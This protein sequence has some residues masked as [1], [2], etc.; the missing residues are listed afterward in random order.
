M[1]ANSADNPYSVVLKSAHY[2]LSTPVPRKWVGNTVYT[3][4]GSDAVLELP[5][6]HAAMDN[7]YDRM[8]PGKNRRRFQIEDAEDAA[9][10]LAAGGPAVV[11]AICGRFKEGEAGKAGR[12]VNRLYW[13]E[14]VEV[15][16]SS[17]GGIPAAQAAS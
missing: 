7:L 1:A 3:Y 5:R 16:Q 2:P 14:R 15:V 8:E 9:F 10:M 17:D 11:C 13:I 6:L 4:S 12:A